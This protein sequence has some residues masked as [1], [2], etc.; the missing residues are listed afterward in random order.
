MKILSTCGVIGLG[1]VLSACSQMPSE[2]E[3]SWDKMEKFAISSG[4]PKDAVKQ[5]KEAFINEIKALSKEEAV[6][7]CKMQ[8]AFLDMAK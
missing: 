6:Q 7:T 1:L 3:E 2:C 5:Q 8:S 4:I